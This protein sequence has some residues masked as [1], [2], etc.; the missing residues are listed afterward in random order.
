[1]KP[2]LR[3]R[4]SR[5]D[6]AK[7]S[8][9]RRPAARPALRLPALSGTALRLLGGALGV[10][11]VVAVLA[12]L[13]GGRGGLPEGGEGAVDEDLAAWCVEVELAA[14]DA[15]AALGLRESWIMRFEP[16]STGGDSV[17][18]VMEFR[19]PGDLH[20]EVLN[21]AMTRAVES[22]GGGIVRGVEHSAARVELEVAR[23]GVMTH[24]FVL[25]R[26]SGYRRHA[27]RLAL[28]IDDFGRASQA[29]LDAFVG[30][31]IPWTATV[32]PGT[33]SATRQARWFSARGVCLL[34]HM[35][36]EPEAGEE[37]EL[38]EGALYTTTARDDV[39]ALVAAALS[40]V[41][42]AR[43]LN[44]HM[45]SAATAD[46]DLMRALMRALADRG[47][48]FLDSRTI[49]SSVAA[50][51]AERAAIPWAERDVFLDPEDDPEII[52]RQFASA[53]DRARR[54]GRA[55]VIGHPRANTLTVL[56][57]R[58]PQ[59]REAGFEFVTV[60]RLLNRPGRRP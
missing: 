57:R 31:G 46:P 30:L 48:F 59:A 13:L 5:E 26:Y 60:D 18:T 39:D 25:Q 50:A 41:P 40:E 2:G 32:I 53:L 1:M 17:L 56:Q 16:G 4:L 55:V 22:L 51:E 38:G 44:N 3:H 47:L 27:G 45:G 33:P 14:R 7:V 54:T 43:G 29:T 52:E 34:V 12:H 58:I 35:P 24:R 15:A 42:G 11:I 28:V 10:V 37:W 36:M 6:R 49:A 23:R 19:F 20:K 8:G 21:L 9:R